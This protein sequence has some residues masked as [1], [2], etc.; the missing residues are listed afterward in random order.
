[1][2]TNL[3]ANVMNAAFADREA[4]DEQTA[5]QAFATAALEQVVMLGD[6]SVDA[7]AT[8]KEAA[9]IADSMMIERAARRAPSPKGPAS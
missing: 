1:M 2:S 3:L 9:A 7:T 5:W 6:G 8:A 4:R